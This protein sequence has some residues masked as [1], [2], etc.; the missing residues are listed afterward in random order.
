MA[1]GLTFGTTTGTGPDDGLDFGGYP[2]PPTVPPDPTGDNW[3]G[4]PGQPGPPGPAGQPGAPGPAGE[5]GSTTVGDAAPALTSGAL[6]FDSV[7]TQLFI[8]YNDGSSTQW[9][10]ASNP[11]A[12]PPGPPGPSYTLPIA[13]TT[14]LGGVKPDGSTIHIDGTGVISSSGGGGLAD[15]PN[16]GTMYARKSAAWSHLTHSDVTDWSSSLP[17]SLPPSG[18]A[19]GDLTGTYPAPTLVTTAVAAGSYTHTS[20]TVDAKGRL[21]AAS[22]GTAPPAPNTVT[23]PL[24]DGTAT[25]GTLATY[26]RPDHVHPVD[27]SRYAASNPSG[28]ISGNQTVTLSGD[29]TGAGATAITATLAASGVTAGSYTSSN[30]TVDAKGRVTAAANGTGGGGASITVGDTPPTLSNGA[31]WFDATSTQ[32]LIGYNDGNSTQW[33][34]ANNSGGSSSGGG[35]MAGPIITKLLTPNPASGSVTTIIGTEISLASG[36][37]GGIYVLSLE[38]VNL[39]DGDTLEIRSYVKPGGSATKRQ[40]FVYSLANGQSN[41]AHTSPQIITE[42]YA[43]FTLRHTTGAPRTLAWS[44]LNLNGT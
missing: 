3:R 19:S 9:V 10:I 38:T 34:V 11:G 25:I 8:G 14:V 39:A 37:A 1:D 15:A 5:D 22:S 24:M 40:L 16:D 43:E 41:P 30:I 20:L 27:T 35:A 32:L 29:V 6:W 33:V 2:Q 13:S 44:V 42:G 28:Y 12:G 36:T 4:P 7:S 17:T 18:A 21:T 26:A 31:M 23:T